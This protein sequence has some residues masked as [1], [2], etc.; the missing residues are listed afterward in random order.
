MRTVTAERTVVAPDAWLAGAPEG[1]LPGPVRRSAPDRW[2]FAVDAGPVEQQVEASIGSV[3]RH[4]P[5]ACRRVAWEP[6]EHPD[7][8]L[9]V[10][11][12]LPSMQAEVRWAPADHPGALVL[13][14]VGRYRPPGRGLGR[15]LDA[16]V[17][18]RVARATVRHL[19]DGIATRAEERRSPRRVRAGAGRRASRRA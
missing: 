13:R 9:R 19:A 5:W 8:L 18:Q 12:L 16:L 4:G 3:W 1:W 6:I 17:L 14:V 10:R 11:P 7:A 15:L 2:R